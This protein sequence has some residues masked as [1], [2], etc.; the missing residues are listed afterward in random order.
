MTAQ[1]GGAAK[2]DASRRWKWI[3]QRRQPSWGEGEVLGQRREVLAQMQVCY[4]HACMASKFVD[5]HSEGCSQF[6]G[7]GGRETE[8][9]PPRSY[10][11]RT[12]G[13]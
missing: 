11:E 1:L 5:D 12:V 10:G 8:Q 6:F 7:W 2:A 3:I 4:P 13:D 9:Q